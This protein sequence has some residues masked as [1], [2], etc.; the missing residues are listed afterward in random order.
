ME[1][2]YGR[3]PQVTQ[4]TSLAERQRIGSVGTPGIPNTSS[5]SVTHVVDSLE[6]GGLERVV[7][8]LVREGCRRGQKV[9]V[10]CL[11]RPGALA[12]EA[13]R[14]GARVVC[15]HKAPGLSR[16]SGWAAAAA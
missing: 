11:E 14:L 4:P 5:L 2:N 13:Q 16:Q 8:A 12:P 9:D 1:L 10:V 7:V 6:C 15:L 3:G